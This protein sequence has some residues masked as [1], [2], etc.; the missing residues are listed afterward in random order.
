MPSPTREYIEKQAVIFGRNPDKCSK[1]TPYHLKVNDAAKTLCLQNPN[2]LND[3]AKLLE[4][5]R[6]KVHTEGYQYRKGASRSKRYHYDMPQ[7]A[8]KRSKTCEDVR[9]RR[10]GE[11]RED[12]Q[13]IDDQIKIKEKRRGIASSSHQYKDCDRL[14]SQ[15]SVL[16]QKLREHKTE[17]SILEKKQKKSVWYKRKKSGSDTS[18]SPASV[19]VPTPS[20]SLSRSPSPIPGFS[21]MPTADTTGAQASKTV[22]CAPSPLMSPKARSHQVSYSSSPVTSPSPMN[23][24]FPMSD[25]EHDTL[26]LSSEDESDDHTSGFHTR[27]QMPL[28]GSQCDEEVGHPHFR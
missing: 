21:S 14:T 25:S 20:S 3:R 2:L 5:S 12:I 15:I 8:P 9:L 7:K 6:E 18:T 24:P 28:S 23:S 17:L 4:L 22:F 26:I 16:R 27:N 10:I 11:L 1:L 19:V 13:D